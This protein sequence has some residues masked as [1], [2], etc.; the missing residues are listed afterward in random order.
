[1]ETLGESNG[2]SISRGRG[3]SALGLGT[4]PAF[5]FRAA[6]QH[7]RISSSYGVGYT[8]PAGRAVIGTITPPQRPTELSGGAFLTAE[9]VARQNDDA[10]TQASSERRAELTPLRDL[11]L[12]YNQVW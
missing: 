6:S 12:A 7:S 10:T 9:K 2:L 8:G 3:Y 1:M 11:G 4:M 5:R